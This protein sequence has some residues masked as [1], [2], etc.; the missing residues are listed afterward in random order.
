[1]T[2]YSTEV[3]RNVYDDELG[4]FITV[5]PSADFPDGNVWLMTEK[6]EVEYWGALSLD[7]PA[8][9]ARKLGE[10]LIAAA[11]EAEQAA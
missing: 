3:H 4:H 7:I 10:A 9:M 6:T 1:M 11:N 2:K 5:R 8:G